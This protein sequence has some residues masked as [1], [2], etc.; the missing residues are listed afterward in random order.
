MFCAGV[1]F[2]RSLSRPG[3]EEAAEEGLDLEARFERHP[4]GAE[5]HVDLRAFAARLKP[6]PLKAVAQSEF[7]RSL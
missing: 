4:S 7:F 5:A 1:E 6:C 2:F 3:A